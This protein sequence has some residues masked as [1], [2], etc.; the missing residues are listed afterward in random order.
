MAR[1]PDKPSDAQLHALRIRGK[2]ARY[3]AELAEATVGRPASRFLA[4]AK[5]FQDL[6]GDHQDA[7]VADATLRRWAATVVSPSTAFAAGRLAERMRL[8]RAAAREA[9]PATWKKL[10]RRGTKAWD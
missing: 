9:L 8:R 5:V 3:A 1:L 4:K 2:R 10:L 6:L 7:V